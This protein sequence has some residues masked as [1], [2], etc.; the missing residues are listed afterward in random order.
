MNTRYLFQC[1]PILAG[2]L[3]CQITVS[4]QTL[5]DV[6]VV[7][8]DAACPSCPP[9]QPF[10]N[11]TVS[12]S[13]KASSAQPI[14]LSPIQTTGL[15]QLKGIAFERYRVFDSQGELWI[16]GPSPADQ[17]IDLA[18]LPAGVYYLHLSTKDGELVH[19]I[20]KGKS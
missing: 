13:A 7:L 12:N 16:G 14:I 3:Y 11:A 19:K 1:L 17:T 5:S 15:I 20:L 6:S 10:Y 2:L 18:Y 4:A 9:A 8:S